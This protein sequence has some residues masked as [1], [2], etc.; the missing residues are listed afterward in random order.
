MCEDQELMVVRN[1]QASSWHRS[2]MAILADL[3]RPQLPFCGA[4]WPK[5][6]SV[7]L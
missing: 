4:E 6:A 7:F 5:P 3:C 2:A 1:W